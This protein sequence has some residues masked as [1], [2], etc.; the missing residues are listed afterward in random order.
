MK[1]QVKSSIIIIMT[2]LIGIVFGIVISGSIIHR[3]FDIRP[4][5]RD[6]ELFMN[7]FE[8]L[9]DIEESQKEEVRSKLKNHF[10]I[11]MELNH[12]HRMQ[13]E[14]LIDSLQNDLN[15]VLTPEQQE[16]LT[17]R[18]ESFKKMRG[19]GKPPFKGRFMDKGR[20][21]SVFKRPPGY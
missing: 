18:L 3:F 12:Q 1:M 2:L 19:F 8:D 16:R 10:T 21:D 6:P 17:E 9:I 13:T 11:I 20:R 14:L 15:K 4:S 7:R 5:F